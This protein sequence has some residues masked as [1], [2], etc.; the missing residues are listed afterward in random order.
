MKKFALVGLV[1]L[2]LLTFN[3][4]A[5]DGG[6]SGDGDGDAGD[7]DG[8]ARTNIPCV[9]AEGVDAACVNDTDCPAVEDGSYRATA[10][11]CLLNNCL[12][13]DDQATCVSDCLVEE[14]AVTA[15]C[16]TCYGTS[17][18]CSAD[19]CL[20]QCAADGDAPKCTECQAEN[21]CTQSFFA[22]SGL[23]VPE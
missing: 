21:G 7:G 18:S 14:L 16:S 20:G 17:A 2:G 12:G 22:C 5:C 13:E 9:A 6:G 8:D 19:N 11:D 3:L 1:A 4:V 10:K 23:A 15:E